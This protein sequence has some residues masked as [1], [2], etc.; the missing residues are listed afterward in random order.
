MATDA[1]LFARLAMDVV[2]SIP[3]FSSLVTASVFFVSTS[4]GIGVNDVFVMEHPFSN[5]FNGLASF[6]KFIHVLVN[7]HSKHQRPDLSKNDVIYS[8]YSRV[9][10]PPGARMV[11]AWK[12]GSTAFSTNSR[13]A[14]N[15][16]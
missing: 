11:A 5:S 9:R 15:E 8:W 3:R 12:S 6:E 2:P 13:I 10:N 16:I 7:P 4:E 14:A 1:S